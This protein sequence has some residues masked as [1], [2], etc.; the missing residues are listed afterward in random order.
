MRANDLNFPYPVLGIPGAISGEEPEVR[1]IS[2]IPSKEL[3]QIPYRWSFEISIKNDTIQKLINEGRA[4]Y[5]C[6]VLC[7]ATLYRRCFFPDAPKSNIVNV[8]IGRKEVNKRVDFSLF[9]VAVDHISD[10][11][12]PDANEDYRELAPFDL[13]AGSPLAVLKSYH[14]DA[15]LCYE[16]LTSLRSILQVLKNTGDPKQEYATLN[17]EH[18]YIQILLPPQQYDAFMEKSQ[19][20]AFAEIIKSSLVLHALQGALVQLASTSE[21]TRR[22]ERA[23]DKYISQDSTKFDG[24]SYHTPGDIPAIALKMLGNPFKGLA[25]IMPKVAAQSSDAPDVNGGDDD[26]DEE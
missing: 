8:E 2:H 16:D 11:D 25:E 13:D 15:D 18:D 23:L 22:W 12:N 20:P 3:I 17:L 7:S 19:I 4:K 9:V 26:G 6:E 14:W 24:L 10:Y 21:I 1:V 5:M